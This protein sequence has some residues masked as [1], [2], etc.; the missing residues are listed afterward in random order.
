MASGLGTLLWLTGFARLLPLSGNL[1]IRPNEFKLNTT[2]K[3]HVWQPCLRCRTLRASSATPRDSTMYAIL[4]GPNGRRHEVDSGDDPVVVNVAMS[5][6]TVQIT[7]T[8]SNDLNS[9]RAR[10]VTVT[11]PREQLA[12]RGATGGEPL[13]CG[14]A[15]PSACRYMDDFNLI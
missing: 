12:R 4:R 11:V 10:F 6:I 8:A 9:D 15:Q 5:D 7:M 2:L 14:I 1:A 3:A 13:T